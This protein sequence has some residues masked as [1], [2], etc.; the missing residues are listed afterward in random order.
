M[1]SQEEKTKQRKMEKSK[2]NERR[3]L[4]T[5][6]TNHWSSQVDSAFGGSIV[7]ADPLLKD[8]E[9]KHGDESSGRGK[10]CGLEMIHVPDVAC[11]YLLL[12]PIRC[13]FLQKRISNFLI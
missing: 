10:I 6:K 7:G 5:R 12:A 9:T 11:C 4:E 2:L 8:L 1:N 13:C 3:S